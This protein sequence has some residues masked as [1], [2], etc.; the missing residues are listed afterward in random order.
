MSVESTSIAAVTDSVLPVTPC[1]TFGGSAVVTEIKEK[2]GKEEVSFLDSPSNS[3]QVNGQDEVIDEATINEPVFCLN[4]GQYDN[5]CHYKMFGGYCSEAVD[6]A[7]RCNPA[8]T[9]RKSCVL[10]FNKAYNRCHNFRMF[11]LNNSLMP[12]AFYLAPSCLKD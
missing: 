2:S 5:L 11:Q 1:T 4:C 10:A 12:K 8:D 9:T 3:D 7:F 6:L